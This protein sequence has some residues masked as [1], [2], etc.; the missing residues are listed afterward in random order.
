MQT[1]QSRRPGELVFAIA[2]VVFS[3]ILLWQAFA[4]SG[5]SGLSTP[6]IF[7]M[8]ATG[9]MLV[10]GL[11]ILRDVVRSR[12][13][14]GG[15]SPLHGFVADIVPL[16][17][18]GMIGLVA[19]YL[20]AMPWVGFL[21]SSAIFLFLSILFLWRRSLLMTTAL[22]AVSLLAVYLVFRVVFQVVLPAG[23]LMRGWS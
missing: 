18:S 5:F 7:P 13:V 10:S 9:T 21:I 20:A 1:R 22:T 19:L 16:R 14:A 4:I 3:A 15:R 6:G 8:L 12:P 17:L 23:T 11:A 2:L